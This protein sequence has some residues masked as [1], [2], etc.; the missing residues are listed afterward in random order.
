MGL[1]NPANCGGPNEW[2]PAR[3]AGACPVPSGTR[4]PPLQ[5]GGQGLKVQDVLHAAGVQV[6]L[7]VER[8]TRTTAGTRGVRA[9]RATG[10]K[11]KDLKDPDLGNKHID[12]T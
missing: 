7:G 10:Q 12:H 8:R 9:P 3:R 11:T 4:V 1:C 6:L 2:R 5:V